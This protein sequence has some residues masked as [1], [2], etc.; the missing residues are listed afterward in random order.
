MTRPGPLRGWRVATV[1]GEVARA[2]LAAEN[3]RR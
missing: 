3:Y 1:T 2:S